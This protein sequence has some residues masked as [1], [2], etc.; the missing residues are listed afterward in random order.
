VTS[1]HKVRLQK[2]TTQCP[3]AHH[4]NHNILHNEKYGIYS[5]DAQNQRQ[6]KL[7]TNT[8]TTGGYFVIQISS[9]TT[10]KNVSKIS[11]LRTIIP[12]KF[13]SFCDTITFALV[14][15]QVLRNSRTW[16]NRKTF[17]IT[18]ASIHCLRLTLHR[19]PFTANPSL[20]RLSEPTQNSIGFRYKI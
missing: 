12:R 6:L 17:L 14:Q 10:K 13:L 2:F 19:K 8:T 15:S 18:T 1:S 9:Q 3:M 11:L 20:Q 7:F 16:Y 4:Y 5:L